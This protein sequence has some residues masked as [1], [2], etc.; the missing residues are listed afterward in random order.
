MSTTG[1]NPSKTLIIE[2]IPPKKTLMD[3]TKVCDCCRQR[4]FASQF[5]Q[6]C[7]GICVECI[8]ADPLCC[9]ADIE[10]TVRS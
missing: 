8:D 1:A 7:C 4:K 9:D 2:I 5:D 10:I 3:A 6:D